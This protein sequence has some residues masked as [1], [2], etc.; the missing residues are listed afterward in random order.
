VPGLSVLPCGPLPPNP[1]ELLTSPRFAQV[2]DEL[3]GLYDF[4]LV[5]TP[6]LLAV[7]DP[8][9]VA[10]RVDGVLLTIRLSRQSGPQ[11]QRA[12]DVLATL[13]ARVLGVVVNATSQ[14]GGPARYESGRYDYDYNY[15][16]DPD[17]TSG[18]YYETGDEPSPVGEK[19][20]PAATGRPHAG[21]ERRTG[22]LRRLFLW[23][24]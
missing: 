3:R 18:G 19:T 24:A 12:R 8:S 22:F 5:D 9:V 17:E 13:D 20:R 6:P 16:P 2:L 11:A 7:T 21:G 10:P 4:V 15:E 14:R 1:A 23:W